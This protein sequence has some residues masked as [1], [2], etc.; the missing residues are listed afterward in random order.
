[1]LDPNVR[2]LDVNPWHW[3]RLYDVI[4][5]PRP[6]RGLTLL[7]Q[8]GRIVKAYDSRTGLRPGL[9]ALDGCDPAALAQQLYEAEH[10]D[11]VQVLDVDALR[12][13]GVTVQAMH[14]WREDCDAYL[15]RCFVARNHFPRGLV[16]VPPWPQEMP[17][18]GVPHRVLSS[19]V[20]G[21]PDGRTLVVAAFAGD[22]VWA[23]IIVRV[24]GGKIV[25]IT[26]TDVFLPE[27]ARW[28]RWCETYRDLLARVDD[29]VGPVHGALLTT[30]QAFVQ[31]VDAK[32]KHTALSRLAAQDEALVYQGGVR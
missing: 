25:L 5:G 21:V 18:A 7:L 28:P 17:I 16:R 14:D 30:Q 24:Q 32:A 29:A 3:R 9:K 6:E 4:F 1:M 26:S 12:D 27:D 13:Y 22:E 31:L 10:P 2:F 11:W 15:A 23:S 19:L 20:A 8:E